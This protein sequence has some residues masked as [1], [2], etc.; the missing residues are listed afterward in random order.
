M[1]RLTV[2]ILLAFILLA[3]AVAQDQPDLEVVK[4]SW[5]K[6]E[7]K[8]IPSGKQAQAMRNAQIDA[9]I[10]EEERKPPQERDINKIIRLRNEKRNQVTPLDRPDPTNRA[11]E[12][13]F[14]FKN[15]G[16]KEVVH[17]YW[18][19]AFRD[20]DTHKPLVAHGF[21]SDTSI[22][23]GKEKELISYTDSSPPQIVNAQAQEKTGKPWTEEVIVSKITYADGSRWERK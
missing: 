13:K 17:V 22:K 11:Y 21:N 1:K 4:F 20:A 3:S 8:T 5:R 12:Y 16:T 18:I 2:S 10:A 14:K 15:H 6:L 7:H 19:F 9:Q 23:P